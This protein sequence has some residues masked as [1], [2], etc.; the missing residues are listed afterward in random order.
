M[1]D[2]LTTA[3]AERDWLLA[4][5]ATTTNLLNRGLR[6]G[7]LA[8]TLNLDAPDAVCALYQAQIDAGAD[9]FLTN[10]YHANA[11]Q[12]ARYGA[13][14]PMGE[15]NITAA[16]LARSVADAAGR[17]VIVAGCIGPTGQI[18]APIGR[19]SHAE[20]V[21]AYTAQARALREGGADLLWVET[22]ASL[23]E[24]RAAAEAARVAGMAWC[25]TL[26]F[27]AAGRTMMGVTPAA[28][29]AAVERLAN[30]PVAYGA[31]CGIGASDLL[32]SINGFAAA[33]S[34]RPM[35]AKGNAGV[36]HLDGGHIHY[37]GT[38]E[39]MADYAVM[40][41][42]LGARIIG[43]CCGTS[44]AHLAA[45][46]DALATR[47]RGP[48]PSLDQIATRLGPFTPDLP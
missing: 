38:P 47:P 32:R 18:M 7:H 21:Q 8:E 30:P 3:L 10:S 12:L 16:R 43:G 41:R 40:A 46:R 5:G 33:G 4:D 17:R 6:R 37:D 9:L 35:I 20:A 26:S 11:F 42:D 39:M 45:M 15:M 36:P 2:L 24:M 25:V 48:R 14:D 23:E 34:E 44:P 1:T 29:A 28:L 13:T 31:N 22:L 27:E 19:L